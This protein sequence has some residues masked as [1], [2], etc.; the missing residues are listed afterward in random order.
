MPKA[1][2]RGAWIYGRY[3]QVPLGE[4]KA[5]LEKPEGWKDLREKSTGGARAQMETANFGEAVL[6]IF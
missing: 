4:L 2:E 5:A 1:S 3:R 6:E